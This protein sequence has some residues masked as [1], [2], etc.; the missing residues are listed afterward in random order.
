MG[1]NL[2]PEVGIKRELI[3]PYNPQQNGVSER[4]N[5][6]IC[7][8]A[9]AMMCDLNLPPSLWVEASSTAI[10]IQNRSPHVILEN[11]TVEEAF[12]SQKPEEGHLR[13]FGC[14]EYIHVPKEKRMKM[15]PSRK[16]GTFVCYRETLKVY[17]IYV[18]G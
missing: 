13:I 18:P 16:N 8:A 6:M 9:K 2:V 15:D 17:R 10:Y 14:P 3:V 12:T 7:E 5:R 4:K 11:K 1:E